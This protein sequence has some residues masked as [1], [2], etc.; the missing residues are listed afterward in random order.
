VAGAALA[1]KGVANDERGF[2]LSGD[3]RF[4]NEADR[5]I[6]T[7]RGWLTAALAADSSAGQR[8]AITAAHAGFERW[9][10]AI[11]KEFAA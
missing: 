11:R 8:R 4:I 6:N 5:R 1:A 10:A 2:L 7:A 9:V 3:P